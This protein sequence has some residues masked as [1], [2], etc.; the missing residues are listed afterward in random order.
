MRQKEELPFTQ[1]SG[2]VQQWWGARPLVSVGNIAKGWV[3][4]PH[5]A[6][7]SCTPTVLRLRIS[8]SSLYKII[9]GI[10]IQC[11]SPFSPPLHN[12][13]G[14]QYHDWPH[15]AHRSE[16][17]E[18]H[19]HWCQDL[20][21][22]C[23]CLLCSA[24]SEF[25]LC[26]SHTVAEKSANAGLFLGFCLFLVG[27]HIQSDL[28]AIWYSTYRCWKALGLEMRI[29]IPFGATPQLRSLW[30]LEQRQPRSPRI[31]WEWQ[32][33]LP[34]GY[35]WGLRVRNFQ[36]SNSSQLPIS[37]QGTVFPHPVALSYIK[38]CKRW[39]QQPGFWLWFSV[40]TTDI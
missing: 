37:S 21:Q 9:T 38:H 22:G 32:T 14:K 26:I 20:S 4:R 12:Q 31:E 23:F 1:G 6:N 8:F 18:A 10:C 30:I 2:H 28:T 16:S 40:N 34:M 17:M 11:R 36:L 7:S 3:S 29:N 25:I 33:L 39:I 24:P 19:S 13:M 27:Y 5:V 35:Q 15:V